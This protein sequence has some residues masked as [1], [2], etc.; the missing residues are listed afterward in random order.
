MKIAT[1]F[2]PDKD[3]LLEG[4]PGRS[5]RL[6][7][8]RDKTLAARYFFYMRHKRVSYIKACE[9]LSSEFFISVVQVQKVLKHNAELLQQLRT[10]QPDIKSLARD[11][12]KW[13]WL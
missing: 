8:Q 11:Y 4:T 5:D 10:S 7:A 6:L 2:D 12:P 9:E 13:V 1:L 3:S